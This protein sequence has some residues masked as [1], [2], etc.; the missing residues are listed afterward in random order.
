MKKAKVI[1][2]P[3]GRGGEIRKGLSIIEASRE[4]GVDIEALCGERKVCGKCKVR[5]EEGFFEE[6]G[7]QSTSKNISPWK[8]EEETFIDAA[9]RIASNMTY[10]DLMNHPTYME[11]FIRAKFLPHTDLS[12]FPSVQCDTMSDA[13]KA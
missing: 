6:Y 3:S 11:E 5:I 13:A 2:Q 8:R 9:E 4:L 1:F 10:F 12:L 7:I